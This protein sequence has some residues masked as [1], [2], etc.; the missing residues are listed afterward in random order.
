MTERDFDTLMAKSW[1]PHDGLPPD[2]VYLHR[3]LQH[4][5]DAACRIIACTGSE[6][7]AALGLEPEKWFERFEVIV[8][9]AAAIHD[10]GKANDHF[11]TMIRRPQSVIQGLRHEWVSVL[12]METLREWIRGV[13]PDDDDWR[14]VRW[15]V[16][17]HHPAYGRASPPRTPPPG[18]GLELQILVGHPHF[19]QCMDW[20]RDVFR[21]LPPAPTFRESIRVPLVGKDNAF[22]QIAAIHHVDLQCWRRLEEQSPQLVRLIAAAKN[23][24]IAADVA[25]SALPREVIDDDA[26]ATWIESAFRRRPTP[27]QLRHLVEEGLTEQRDNAA[28]A[29]PLRPFQEAVGSIDGDVVLVTAGCGSGKTLAAYHRAARK[30]HSRRLYL[31]YPTTGTATEGFR[32][33]LVS[34]GSAKFQA[35]LFHGRAGID[36]EMLHVVRED[37]NG[38]AE[39]AARIESLDAWST[40]IV[41]CTADTVLGLVQN[42]RRGLFAWPALAG[43]A[44][45]FDEIH[46]YDD[47]LYGALLRFLAAMPGAPILLMTASLPEHRRRSLEACLARR[48]T[49]LTVVPGP[50]DLERRRRYR[51]ILSADAA[52]PTPAVR[53]EIEAR[54]KVLWVCNT[55][56][57]ALQAADA[58]A[59]LNPIVYHS[60]FR[61]VDRIQRH[62]ETVE[63]FR[64]DGPALAIC[65]QVAEMSLDLSATLLVTDL[66]PVPA[67]I[68]RLG[69]LNRRAEESDPTRPFIVVE[70]RHDDGTVQHLPYTPEDLTLAR[71]WL[72]VL[73]KEISQHDLAK[74]W[75]DDEDVRTRRA[76]YVPSAWLDGGPVTQV[77]E[78]R[79]ASPGIS[80]IMAADVQSLTAELCD[81]RRR[82]LEVILPMPPAPAAYSWRE[83]PRV[84]GVPI[85]PGGTIEYDPLRGARWI[86]PK[87]ERSDG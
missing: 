82:L 51:R 5:H 17:G 81:V 66:A 44:F 85:A 37:G 57:R 73:P 79:E 11:Q 53:A 4:V 27:V 23:C 43:A 72:D 8:Q 9:V 76:A 26:R 86:D 39:A 1:P 48:G 36:L 2:S 15:L 14:I 45:V 78:L 30:W 59:E 10:L 67:L 49:P 13:V 3:H 65:T 50:E 87:Q 25:G 80:V 16:S 41:C 38:A 52:N 12:L 62:A 70:P 56:N 63:A 22:V 19:A 77:L 55:V 24:L 29:H 75:E 58:V 33:Y 18:S 6:Q 71:R 20:M 54:G 68:Q 31:C 61:Y 35:D 21:S 47:R 46:A 84:N 40:P 60:R 34:G 69:R 74:A 42:N 7:L 28:V 64:Q 83:W 32:D